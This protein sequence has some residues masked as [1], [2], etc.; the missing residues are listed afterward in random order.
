MVKPVT[1]HRLTIHHDIK[2]L[3]YYYYFPFAHLEHLNFVICQVL[4]GDT[5]VA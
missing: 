5:N 3:Y 2:T 1:I 4:S